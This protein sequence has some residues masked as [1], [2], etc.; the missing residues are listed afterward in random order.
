M[1]YEN[2]IND[3]R[4]S[5]VNIGT[6]SD[7]CRT[8]KKPELHHGRMI[9][10][11]A[12]WL[13]ESSVWQEKVTKSKSCRTFSR[14][15]S[16]LVIEIPY[17]VTSFSSFKCVHPAYDSPLMLP[18]DVRSGILEKFNLERTPPK[19]KE[20]VPTARVSLQEN[21]APSDGLSN[22]WQDQTFV[23]TLDMDRS[24]H[25]MDPLNSSKGKSCPVLTE[26]DF[27]E[28]IGSVYGYLKE[29]QN[30]VDNAQGKSADIKVPGS[31]T[32]VSLFKAHINRKNNKWMR[33]QDHKLALEVS[34]EKEPKTEAP[35]KTEKK[36]PSNKPTNNLS[37]YSS[38]YSE[39][40]SVSNGGDAAQLL[41]DVAQL[42]NDKNLTYQALKDGLDKYIASSQVSG[43]ERF[44]FETLPPEKTNGLKQ[45]LDNDFPLSDVNSAFLRDSLCRFWYKDEVGELP[46]KF[47]TSEDESETQYPED[48]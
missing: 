11:L 3:L 24:K 22:V 9:A 43:L 35:E 21:A 4:R 16:H 27:Y 2:D 31:E 41:D 38:D 37:P 46:A 48:K 33:R 12:E 7:L 13:E 23:G 17:K 14:E 25:G 32:S 39:V 5:F 40:V 45:T 28:P 36:A 19:R 29:V 15:N 1:S 18:D 47:A 34:G 6:V 10:L 20:R 42:V 44:I 30:S 8:D 26:K